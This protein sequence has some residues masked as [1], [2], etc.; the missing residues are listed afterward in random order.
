MYNKDINEDE[1]IKY[2]LIYNNGKFDCTNSSK[3][4]IYV[5]KMND[6]DT[7]NMNY[8]PNI[9]YLIKLGLAHKITLNTYEKTISL[10][11]FNNNKGET[12]IEVIESKLPNGQYARTDRVFVYI[13]KEND[14]THPTETIKIEEAY[15]LG[16]ITF[17]E[18]Q[19]TQETNLSDEWVYKSSRKVTVFDQGIN[20]N[21]D[22]DK[23]EV[24]TTGLKNRFRDQ[25]KRMINIENQKILS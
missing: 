6:Y 20:K 24:K 5:R 11:E 13:F 7:I 15:K 10:E 14:Y 22:G 25:Y 17:K 18:Q 1:D 16:Y 4:Y 8:E 12:I 9:E 19:Q 2:D 3:Y 21:A 23:I